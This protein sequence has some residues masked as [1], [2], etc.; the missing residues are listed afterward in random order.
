MDPAFTWISKERELFYNEGGE[1]PRTNKIL[2]ALR[3]WPI[4]E[5]IQPNER[6][7]FVGIKE[8]FENELRLFVEEIHKKDSSVEV[9]PFCMHKL[10]VGG[11]DRFFYKRIFKD[12]DFVLRNLDLTH[13]SPESDLKLFSTARSV[14]AMRFHSVVFS[15]GTDTTFLALDYTNGGKIKG[16]LEMLSLQDHLQKMQSFNGVEAAGKML[17]DSYGFSSV[18]SFVE[19]S[20]NVYRKSIEN[21]VFKK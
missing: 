13:S 16:L 7:K 8:N 10:A 6:D 14:L 9:I 19:D 2:L 12:H 3:D 17:T 20:K 1:L 21:L 15:I 4:G 18:E 11:D 5:Y